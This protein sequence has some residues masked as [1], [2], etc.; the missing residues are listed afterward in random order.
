MFSPHSSTLRGLSRL[1]RSS[2][3]FHDQLMDALYGDE[4][5]VGCLQDIEADDLL[6]LIDYLEEVR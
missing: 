5:Y 1:K 3:D 2:L 6:W 4:Y